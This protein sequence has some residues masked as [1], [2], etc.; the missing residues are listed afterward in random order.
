MTSLNKVFLMG[1]LTRDPD[2]RYIPNGTPVCEM[3]MAINRTFTAADGNRREEPCFVDL[4]AWRKTA[5]NAGQYLKKGS[6]VFVEGYLKMDTWESAGGQKRSKIRVVASTIVFLDRPGRAGEG[7]P[8]GGLS[9]AASSAPAP[10]MPGAPEPPP[11]DEPEPPPM[12]E[13]REDEAPPAMDDLP[14]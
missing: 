12:R 8:A 5:E 4:T 2:L 3:G 13:P 11:P 14:F 1:R 9:E 10:S 6:S 7:K